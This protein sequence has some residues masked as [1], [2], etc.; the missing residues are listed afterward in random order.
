M[1]TVL[2]IQI[3]IDNITK[4]SIVPA[5]TVQIRNRKQRIVTLNLTL[6]PQSSSLQ[7]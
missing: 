6:L 5:L 3:A 2:K 7:S 4:R 1:P